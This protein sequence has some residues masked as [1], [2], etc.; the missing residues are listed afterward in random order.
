MIGGERLAICTKTLLKLIQLCLFSM[1]SM[2]Y[3]DVFL[4][5][6]GRFFIFTV[7]FLALICSRLFFVPSE[8]FCTDRVFHFMQSRMPFQSEEF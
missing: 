2:L 6:K 1:I 3:S 8:I 5:M 7:L 4:A